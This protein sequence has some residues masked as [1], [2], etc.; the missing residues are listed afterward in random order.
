MITMDELLPAPDWIESPYVQLDFGNWTISE[1]APQELKERF[2]A[3]MKAYDEAEK[4][5]VSV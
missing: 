1:N 2:Y 3:W 4:Q 5:G